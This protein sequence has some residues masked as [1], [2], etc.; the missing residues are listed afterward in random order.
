MQ[1][2]DRGRELASLGRA[3]PA[4]GSAL[5]VL[6]G[7]R[8]IG[9]S[10]LLRHFFA[11]RRV[12]FFTGD[13]GT[14]ALHVRGLARMLGEVLDD[15]FLENRPPR[16][17]PT[18]LDYLVSRTGP[19]DL[20]L[21]EFPYLC[22]AEPALPSLIQR[23]WD[24]TWKDREVRLVLC[25]SSVGFME[26]EVLSHKSPLFGRRTGQMRLRAMDFWGAR[27]FFPGYGPEQ[28]L[29]AYAVLGG[30]PAWLAKFE[31][32]LSLADNLR[33]KILD[34]VSYLYEEPRLLLHQE[35]REPRH[36]FSILSSLAAGNTRLNEIAQDTGLERPFVSRYLHSLVGLELVDR[37]VP[38][39]ETDPER[40][41]KGLYRLSDPFFRFWF[42]FVQ[43]HATALQAELA[44]DVLERRIQPHLAHFVAPVFEQLCQEWIR[45]RAAAGELSFEPER[46]GRWW[47]RGQE[48]D[49]VAFD[50]ERVL[51]GECKWS[52]SPVGPQVLR[53]LQEKA[54]QVRELAR[55]SPMFALFSRAGFSG[56]QPGPDLLLV[57]LD[58]LV[59]DRM[60]DTASP[61]S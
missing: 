13:L 10:E 40:S 60:P 17:W 36:Y 51:F 12:V 8:R 25:G 1:F 30:T 22:Q 32:A 47:T 23:T 15:R 33:R 28:Q 7:R 45:R 6:Y 19:L 58:A 38:V 54:A 2:V 27:L 52:T 20:V 39:T 37:E 53:D 50:R 44:Q 16:D 4:S 34:P 56:L 48:I 35:F 57:D 55:R 3:I 41:R 24:E 61:R 5:F 46:V 42:R 11:S 26:E 18:L 29:Q 14:P 21:D 43:P 59:E 31:P 9:K 49:V